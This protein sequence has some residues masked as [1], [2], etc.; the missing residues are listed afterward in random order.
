MGVVRNILKVPVK[1][2]EK[3][4]RIV[5]LVDNDVELQTLWRCSNVQSIDR[6]GYSDHGPVH[7][8]IVANAALKMLR[9]LIN[10]GVTPN[11]VKDHEMCVED[12]EVV[13]FL[14]AIMHDIGISVIRE[15][16]E[17]YSVL[18]AQRILERYLPAAYTPE[19]MTIVASE[20]LH[21]IICHHAPRVPL[22]IEAGIV[23][24]ADALDMEKGRSRIPFEAGKID[25][26]SVSALSI[27]EVDIAEGE[28]KPILIRIKMTNPAGI[29]Q[30]DNL[31][32]AKIKGS[33]LE[34]YIH[35]EA[36]I[37]EEGKRVIERFEL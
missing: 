31:L 32:G 37:G 13:V 6:M 22:T 3:L 19:K 9:I 27:E 1:G 14:A 21:A 29:F 30:V 8:K 4:K 10:R 16:H 20:V 24:I 28:D 35:V 18:L 23:K 7:A 26:H 25:I 33:G 2:N 36:V 5:G 17:I 15:G 11:I 12:A 34:D